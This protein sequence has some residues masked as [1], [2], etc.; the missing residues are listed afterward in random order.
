MTE[1]PNA[2]KETLLF[3]GGPKTC[4]RMRLGHEFATRL[5]AR[6]EEG[7]ASPDRRGWNDWIMS[8]WHPARAP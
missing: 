7:A 4:S 1:K 6:A 2:R 3:E 8:D 5:V